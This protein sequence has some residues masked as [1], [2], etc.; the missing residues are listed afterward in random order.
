M[1]CCAFDMGHCEILKGT[2]LTGSEDRNNMRLMQ[3]GQS[4]L[5]SQKT[6]S[7][8]RRNAPMTDD[9]HSNTAVEWVLYGFVDDPHPAS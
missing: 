6:L 7:R 2:L 1:Q 9:L 5:L 8:V 3:A 4:A